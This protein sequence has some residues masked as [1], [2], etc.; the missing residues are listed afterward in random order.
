[1]AAPDLSVIIPVWNSER[2]LALCLDALAA[3]QGALEGVQV[4]VVDNGSTDE[5]RKVAEGYCFVEVFDEPRPGSYCA[6]NKG[7]EHA[8]GS[9][10]CFV[11]SDCIPQAN[12]IEKIREALV[13]HPE[14]GILAG[15]IELFRTSAED[16]ETCEAYE[17]LFLLN[18][19]EYAKRGSS[20]TANWTSPLSIIR[21]AGGFNANLKSGGDFEMASRIIAA[22]Y[23]IV[24]CPEIV[25][26]H[27]V[28]GRIVDT[29]RKRAR[30]V[31]GHW[32]KAKV[33]M[34]APQ[35][36]LKMIKDGLSAFVQVLRKGPP[37]ILLKAKLLGLVILLT[38]VGLAEHLRLLLGGTPRRA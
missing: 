1:M 33:S 20:A 34:S 10:V 36:A 28:R 18:Q 3:Q 9:Y 23:P 24:Y 15:R 16:S 27:P 7:L 12:W 2:Q 38:L 4:I 6:R 26:N 30:V 35:F 31:G 37:N 32:T 11:D 25:V 21:L 29:L 22:G 14:A 5:T 8:K 13:K 17:R 19:E